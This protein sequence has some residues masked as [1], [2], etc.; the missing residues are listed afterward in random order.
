[1]WIRCIN[2]LYLGSPSCTYS[3]CSIGYHSI[4]MV[5]SFC[6]FSSSILLSLPL[7]LSV[8]LSV[9]LSLFLSLSLSHSLSHSLSLSLSFS[10]ILSLSLFLS[11]TLYSSHSFNLTNYLL[12]SLL[13]HFRSLADSPTATAL[14]GRILNLN[15]NFTLAVYHNICRSLFEK[16]KLLFAFILCVKVSIISYTS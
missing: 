3:T 2:I 13:S 16:H 8:S 7:A 9:S 14:S 5:L 4:D 1:M 12:S 15:E 11:L 10:L 6:F